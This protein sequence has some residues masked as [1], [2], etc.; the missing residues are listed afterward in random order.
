M[1]GYKG[2]CEVLQLGRGNCGHSYTLGASCPEHYAEEDLM[3]LVD[4]HLSVSQQPALAA[5]GT[6]RI[7]HE[8][9]CC[10]QVKGGGHQIL[11]IVS[12]SGLA[13][14]KKNLLE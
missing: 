10:Q 1:K 12:S 9:E 13:V 3:V 5:K 7:P 2:E 14:E 6:S 8:E 4:T 11:S